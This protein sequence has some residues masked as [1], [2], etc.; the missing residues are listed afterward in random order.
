[1]MEHVLVVMDKRHLEMIPVF[2]GMF[3]GGGIG[4]GGAPQ[5]EEVT[6]V[7]PGTDCDDLFA[8]TGDAPADEFGP[9]A[10]SMLT[11]TVVI[12]FTR[13]VD[14]KKLAAAGGSA[15]EERTHN[16]KTYYFKKSDQSAAWFRDPATAIMAPEA[17]VKSLIEGQT[18]TEG[19]L[20]KLMQPLADREFAIGLDVRPL[21]GFIGQL[22]Q[23]NPAMA[24]A[25]GYVK[26]VNTL[27]L[28]ADLEGANLLELQL[29][30][31][32]DNSAA[33]LQ[34]M[35]GQ[36]LQQGQMMY[37]Q[38]MQQ[39]AKTMSD[40]DKALVPLVE[41]IVNGARV[42]TDGS[43]C[44]VTVPRPEGLEKLPELIRPQL[45]KS[46]HAAAS[47]RILNDLK[48]I[49]VAFHNYNDSYRHFPANGGRGDE[50]ANGKGLSWRVHLLPFVEQTPLY[51]EFNLDEPW[52]SAHNKPLIAR[53]PAI[54]GNDP[55]GKTTIHVFAGPG[56]PFDGEVGIKLS[57]VTDGT[58][59][60]IL[61][62]QAG[63]GTAE[64]WTKPG[65]LPLN[66]DNPV[67]ALGDV[68]ETF[69]V[70]FMDAFARR[71]PKDIDADTLRNLIQPADGNIVRLD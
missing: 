64:I 45:K 67:T 20:A 4:P 25:G 66:A 44:R 58:S 50:Q 53:M 32:N 65:G 9:D 34:A 38:Q 3:L 63:P 37:A 51:N 19:P 57:Q 59:N 43:L 15:A 31:I 7:D 23:E 41:Q 35:L 1:D 26:Q 27:A 48:M 24:L 61:V 68:G 2:A 46:A 70:I 40:D 42:A 71:L 12:K 8:P 13:E 5:L 54:Y 21:H 6:P 11:P 16:G 52:D 39:A 14:G 49:G 18:P 47:A 55:E 56:T 62:V 17:K 69:P 60:T 22:A 36:L 29:H 30:A 33:G 28:A 10:A